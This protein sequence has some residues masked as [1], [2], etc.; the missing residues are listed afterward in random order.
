M[1]KF[2]A[3]CLAV[4]MALSMCS[5]VAMAEEITF[6]DI[7]NGQLKDFIVS[8]LADLG[9]YNVESSNEDVISI[10]GE[11]TRPLLEDE[12]V[13]LTVDGS[14]FDV[15]VKA[16]TTKV[17]YQNNFN[18]AIGGGE[19]DEKKE[20]VGSTASNTQVE[21]WRFLNY[22]AQDTLSSK[23][24]A[25]GGIE[26]DL[27]TYGQQPAY[28]FN[29][30]MTEPFY[31]QL[32]AVA[33]AAGSGIEVR[34]IYKENVEGATEKTLAAY[35]L[36]ATKE[37]RTFGKYPSDMQSGSKNF[38]D[39]DTNKN[40]LRVYVDPVNMIA[41]AGDANG[42]MIPT[43]GQSFGEEGKGCTVT[44]I[45][46]TR[47]GS[48]SPA[49]TIEIDNFAVTQEVSAEN[50]LMNA[51]DEEKLGYFSQYLDPTTFANGESL[52]SV[53][54][55]LAL[56]PDDMDLET[57]GVEL[58]WE[59]SDEAVIAADGTITKDATLTKSAVIKG[60]LKVGS[61]ETIT[62]TFNVNVAPEG[63]EMFLGT[64]SENMN[65][66]FEDEVAGTTSQGGGGY[67]NNVKGIN[68]ASGTT[69][70]YK[71]DTQRGMI[72][73]YTATSNGWL[74][75]FSG[76]R[77]GDHSSRYLAGFDYKFSVADEE[78]DY[79]IEYF[80]RGNNS[81][82]TTVKLTKDTAEAESDTTIVAGQ[83]SDVTGSKSTSIWT[84][85]IEGFENV[86]APDVWHTLAVDYNA[87][88]NLFLV[89]VDGMLVTK[90]PSGT[91]Q[92]SGNP[93]M[94]IQ[95]STTNL[96]TVQ[97]DNHYVVEYSDADVIIADG[98]LK[99]AVYNA[100]SRE[101]GQNSRPGIYR[102]IDK[103]ALNTVIINEVPTPTEINSATLSWKVNGEAHTGETYG[104]ATTAVNANFEVT[105]TS[106][107]VTLTTEFSSKFAP[108]EILSFT[109]ITRD[110]GGEDP[111]GYMTGMTI[112]G[113]LEGKTLIAMAQNDKGKVI[114]LSVIPV[115]TADT[116][117]TFAEEDY[118]HYD[119][120]SFYVLDNGMLTPIVFS[121]G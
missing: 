61:L 70:T 1:K 107:D 86:Y 96:D 6:D 89:Y 99:N 54:K 32:D 63:T 56:I 52:A 66:D 79:G 46:I 105:A 12:K 102:I 111:V 31:F 101:T 59:T 44:N 28:V 68:V 23:V 40:T 95:L 75:F 112:E 69:L 110:E 29:E 5:F 72:A 88:A 36:C 33:V 16:Q 17:L 117:I 108:A 51:T 27:T 14:E 37:T 115:T 25:T 76:V 116:T 9:A 19:Y 118:V 10:Y 104:N 4:L 55:D 34:V 90:I 109:Y 78:A 57:L 65:W 50:A 18:T 53:T 45:R 20:I 64:K 97:I 106:G 85:K 24:G 47:A 26:F 22:A 91:H 43:A 11:V 39:C 71:N 74:Q 98:A 8:D 21:G 94:W 120:A 30:P 58:T 114:D 81:G 103:S 87:M 49:G 3:I 83:T 121:R 100:A 62:K 119:G 60:T 2:T 93:M 35:R 7:S 38:G 67:S 82:M 41:R 73:E 113:S 84:N 13:T 15:T 77:S 92:T 80:L 48:S 42:T